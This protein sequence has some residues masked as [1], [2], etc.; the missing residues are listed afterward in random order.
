MRAA[1]LA[2]WI[3]RLHG[4]SVKVA[5]WQ[6]LEESSRLD[7]FGVG[8]YNWIQRHAPCLH[9]VFFNFLELA[10]LHRRASRIKGRE[11]YLARLREL[12]PDVIVSTHAHLNHGYFELAKQCLGA[13]LRCITYCGEL[14]GGYGFSRHW[15][16]PAADG[17][18]AAVDACASAAQ[19][20]GMP[21]E[22]AKLGGFLL[23]PQFFEPEADRMARSE[24]RRSLLREVGER[25]LLL[26]GT[27]ANGANNH[28]AIIRSLQRIQSPLGIVALCG[29]NA[30]ALRQLKAMNA[31]AGHHRIIP[32]SYRED[33]AAILR[34]V[35]LAFVRPGTGTTSECIVCD[36]PVV[37][38]GIGG[39]MPQEG[40]TLKYLAS[41]GIAAP[42]VRRPSQLSR[43]VEQW[44]IDEPHGVSDKRREAFTG[45]NRG[46]TPA[47]IVQEVLQ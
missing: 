12:T 23:R 39:V 10:G 9:H 26:L 33:M 43:V 35:D 46:F 15:V 32:L 7:R 6:A 5:R 45:I 24:M 8:L 29:R 31:E 36:C 27:G 2:E 13:S 34:A 16:N 28:A 4:D 25:P 18:I 14:S 11:R 3:E 42:L 30:G 22:K 38:N 17:F 19:A 20:H 40:I 47:G 21:V 41:K 37:F 1:A 44:L